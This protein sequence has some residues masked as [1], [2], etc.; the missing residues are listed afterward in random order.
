[1]SQ[2]PYPHYPPPTAAPIQRSDSPRTGSYPQAP[3]SQ[4]PHLQNPHIQAPRAQAEYNKGGTQP[5]YSP[6]GPPQ[7]GS[8]APSNIALPNQVFSSP[9]YGAQSNGGLP[10]HNFSTGSP[11]TPHSPHTPY[12]SQY[13]PTNHHNP[14]TSLPTSQYDAPQLRGGTMGPPSRPNDKPTDINDLGDV[15]AGSGVDL[16]EE[17]AAM[18]RFSS[19]DRQYGARQSNELANTTPTPYPFTRDNHYSPYVPGDRQ[20]FYGAG[21]YNQPAVPYKSAELMA[22]ENKKRRIR[23][24][25]EIKQYH[26]NDPF[27]LAGTLRKKML[28]EVNKYHIKFDDSGLFL[29]KNPPDPP[30]KRTFYGPDGH[31]VEKR[32]Y[33]QAILQHDS[34]LVEILSLL[35]LATQERMRMLVEDAATLARGRRVGAL[36]IVPSDLDGLLEGNETSEAANA[37]PTPGDSAVS[38]SSNPLKRMFSLFLC[39]GSC[40]PNS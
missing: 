19:T 12:N 21:F 10:N 13:D 1:M 38:P 32:L 29:P 7:Y 3:P 4:S 8:P 34:T 20:S 27:L 11:Y 33:N 26:L 39:M 40:L 31:G 6:H 18:F 5:M 17:E 28:T 25:A 30:Q 9:Y 35:S 15:L 37:L 24:R 2:R 22:E 14:P 23:D 36:G 16:R